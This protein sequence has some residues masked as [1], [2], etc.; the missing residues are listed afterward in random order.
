MEIKRIEKNNKIIASVYLCLDYEKP[1]SSKDK[2]ISFLIKDIVKS[3]V[4]YAG[5]KTKK[6][7]QSHPINALFGWKKISLESLNRISIKSLF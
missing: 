6:S 4:G 5:F 1:V 7:L 3:P 2:F